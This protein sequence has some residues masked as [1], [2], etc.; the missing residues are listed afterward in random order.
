MEDPIENSNEFPKKIGEK[1]SWS[2]NEAL[3]LINFFKSRNE[4]INLAKNRR[5]VWENISNDLLSIDVTKSAKCCE[6]KWKNMVRTYRS[7]K[8]NNKKSRRRISRFLFLNEM[9]EVIGNQPSSSCKSGASKITENNTSIKIENI[10]EEIE[11]P[12]PESSISDDD[13]LD[14]LNSDISNCEKPVTQKRKLA[15]VWIDFF[16]LEKEALLKKNEYYQKKIEI[17]KEE[18]KKTEE[19]EERKLRLKERQLDI[20]ERKVKALEAYLANKT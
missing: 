6:V 19:R 5:D 9:D 3:A 11:I 15:N 16:E 8:E 4:E 12:Y 20:E 7:V 17:I 14:P 10:A 18:R 2:K 13:S 1:D